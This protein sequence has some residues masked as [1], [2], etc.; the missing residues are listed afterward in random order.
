MALK[1]DILNFQ[2]QLWDV[3]KNICMF[4]YKKTKK[5]FMGLH[6]RFGQESGECGYTIANIFY[7]PQ[8]FLKEDVLVWDIYF[9]TS[10]F[11]FFG[12][13]RIGVRSIE[14]GMGI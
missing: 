8:Y 12:L 6:N 14:N 9:R 11:C 4:R 5:D 7:S 10:R 1:E 3:E 2:Y 13:V